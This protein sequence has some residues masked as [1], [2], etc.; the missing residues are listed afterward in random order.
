M[1][2]EVNYTILSIIVKMSKKV[3]GETL[4]SKTYKIGSANLTGGIDATTSYL[5]IAKYLI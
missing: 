4:G 5:F 3:P 1:L 2:I